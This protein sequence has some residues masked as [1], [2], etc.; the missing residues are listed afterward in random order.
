MINFF[1]KLFTDKQAA[2]DEKRTADE[3]PITKE[4]IEQ[5]MKQ[6]GIYPE[7]ERFKTE[8]M[9]LTHLITEQNMPVSKALNTIQDKTLRD[10]VRPHIYSAILMAIVQ[11]VQHLHGITQEQA[12]DLLTYLEAQSDKEH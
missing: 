8:M 10:Q 3:T 11:T 9:Y 12:N 1:K 5:M 6:I 4:V 2:T 7:I